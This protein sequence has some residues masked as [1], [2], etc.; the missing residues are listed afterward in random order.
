MPEV[1]HEAT[2]DPFADFAALVTPLRK[3]AEEMYLSAGALE[4]GDVEGFFTHYTTALLYM[5]R[6]HE[7]LHTPPATPTDADTSPHD[8]P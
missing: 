6:C 2:P 8:L 1:P 4:Q 7:I 5:V 3:S